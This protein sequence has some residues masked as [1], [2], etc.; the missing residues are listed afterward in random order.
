MCVILWRC[1]FICLPV[2]SLDSVVFGFLKYVDENKDA[3]VS[4]KIEINQI[5]FVQSYLQD[6]ELLAT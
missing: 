2:C 1:R 6:E 5:K 3:S 4:D